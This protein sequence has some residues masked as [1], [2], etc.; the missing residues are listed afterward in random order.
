MQV[1]P[2]REVEITLTAQLASMPTRTLTW[3]YGLI[4]PIAVASLCG[5]RR[6]GMEE[7]HGRCVLPR[8]SQAVPG[9]GG[10]WP[11]SMMLVWWVG[12]ARCKW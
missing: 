12:L 7:R 5:V 3:K 10:A 2:W 8:P 4:L 6:F 1:Y 9:T 11:A